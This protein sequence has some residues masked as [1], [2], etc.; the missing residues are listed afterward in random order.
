VRSLSG[1]DQKGR[2]AAI[3]DEFGIWFTNRFTGI[4][5][6]H[7]PLAALAAYLQTSFAELWLLS[8]N[9]SRTLRLSVLAKLPVPKLPGEWWERAARLFPPN[10]L[11]VA[12]RWRRVPNATLFGEP[13]SSE[14]WEW[15]ERSV[16]AALG[17]DVVTADAVEAYL[18]RTLTIGSYRSDIS[19]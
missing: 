1:R 19:V 7:I 5:S 8:Q 17:F 18:V 10:A 2:L 13:T 4:W 6:D 11:A 14:E 15:F 3:I 16:N 9:P 12:P